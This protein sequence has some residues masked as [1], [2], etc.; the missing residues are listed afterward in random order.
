MTQGFVKLDCGIV[1][2]TIWAEPDDVLRAWIALLAKADAYG[3]VRVSIPALAILCRTTTARAAEIIEIFKAPDRYSRSPEFD[4]RRVEERDG[5]L[6]LLNYVKHRELTQGKP[7]SHAERQ[8]RYR[9]RLANRDDSLASPV[10]DRRVTKSNTQSRTKDR[11]TEA[12]VEVK[13]EHELPNGNSSPSAGADEP[14]TRSDPIPYQAIVDVFNR[15]LTRLPK[16]RTLTPKRRTLIRS[17]WQASP[18]RRSIEFWQALAE[19]YEADDFTNGTGPYLHG[20]E[21]WR[22]SIDYLLRADVVTRTFERAMD[23]LERAA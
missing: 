11:D 1:D 20:H 14:A 17:A 16:A 9:D 7:G 15:T 4:G 8:R 21:G 6:V 19:E 2:S 13:Q 18:E 10:T 22:P 5:A 23:H 12:E 3:I